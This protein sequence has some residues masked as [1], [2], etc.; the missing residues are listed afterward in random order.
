MMFWDGFMFYKVTNVT[1]IV[2]CQTRDVK[3]SHSD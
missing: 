2:K 1:L 3:A